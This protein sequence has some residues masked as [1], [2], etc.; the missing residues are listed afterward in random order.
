[1]DRGCTA[2]GSH[3]ESGGKLVKMMVAISHKA[4]I[5]LCDQYKLDGQYFE[6]LMLREF[7]VMLKKNK[8]GH[9]HLSL[10]GGD[11]GQNSAAS[12]HKMTTEQ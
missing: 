2:K 8:K 3:E 10:Q 11:P 7:P 5:V 12:P 4:G 9:S 6:N 1:M